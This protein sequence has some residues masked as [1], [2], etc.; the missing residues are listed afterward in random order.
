METTVPSQN[1]AIFIRNLTY[2]TGVRLV[3]LITFLVLSPI[4]MTTT[5]CGTLCIL[6]RIAVASI[7]FS[8]AS[9]F[10]YA[11]AAP[12]DSAAKIREAGEDIQIS[13]LAQWK[14][15]LA[16]FPDKVRYP[17]LS[18][19]WDFVNLMLIVWITGGAAS[20][21][22]PLFVI[23]VLV[24]DVC[25]Q[26]RR[27]HVLMFLTFSITTVLAVGL[28]ELNDFRCWLLGVS[29]SSQDC[30]YS[31]IWETPQPWATVSLLLVFIPCTYIGSQILRRY[32]AL[33]VNLATRH[34]P[35]SGSR[36][37]PPA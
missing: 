6:R 4:S 2:H 11:Q 36:L 9:W 35:A 25:R 18:L 15:R 37:V 10:L 12:D 17:L 34:R 30:G 20:I 24:G 22:L 5:D 21:Y 16:T 32:M 14:P 7:V 19:T 27:A 3:I 1:A 13:V 33:S 23:A 31:K 8:I 28:P 26:D 29:P